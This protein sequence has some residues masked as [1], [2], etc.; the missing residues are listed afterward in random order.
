[1]EFSQWIRVD[2]ILNISPSVEG[3][4]W[5]ASKVLKVGPKSFWIDPPKRK[6]TPLAM[7]SGSEIRISVPSGQGLFLFASRVLGEAIEPNPSIE[8]EYPR[9][10][11]RM[12]RRAYPRL[13]IRLETYY[14]EIHAG[15]GGLVF[16]RSLALDLSGGG[17]RLETHRPCPQETLVRLKFHI[18]VGDQ[19]EE[20]VVTGR[21]ARTIPTE[22]MRRNQ[23][24]VEFLD[25][26]PRQQKSLVQFIIGNL[27]EGSAQA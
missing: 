15:T 5:Y 23:A 14:A 17:V 2:G 3:E 4:D 26:T 7:E 20:V 16:T 18:P 25:I 24:G 10:I 1:M 11:T 21:I 9:E 13:P 19:V 8:L 12:E 6:Y 22:G 27:D